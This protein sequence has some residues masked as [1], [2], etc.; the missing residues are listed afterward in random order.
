MDTRLKAVVLLAF[1][2]CQSH[3]LDLSNAVI[4]KLENPSRIEQKAIAML[5]DE[6]E[7]RTQ[8]TLP[9]GEPEAN[10][11][12]IHLRRGSGPTEGFSVQ[13]QNKSVEI[14]GNDER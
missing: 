1:I 13:V 4:L 6:V 8:L 11:P 14:A 2:V 10:Q 12:F 5:I 7:K 3:A 9:V